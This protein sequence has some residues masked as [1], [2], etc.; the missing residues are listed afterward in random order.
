MVSCTAWEYD[1]TKFSKTL[2]SEF[3]LVCDRENLL[4]IGQTVYF[5]G[6][7]CGSA[8]FGVLSDRLGRKPMLVLSM[9]L[10]AG[11][12]IGSGLAT[13][14]EMFLVCRFFTSM[15]APRKFP[16]RDSSQSQV[17]GVIRVFILTGV[18]F[19]DSFIGKGLSFWAK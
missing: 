19:S 1:Q 6:V 9:L 12:G 11:S 5:L 2:A 8:I 13:N 18:S 15:G 17:I 16:T 10:M 14:F 3:D 7:L 4:S